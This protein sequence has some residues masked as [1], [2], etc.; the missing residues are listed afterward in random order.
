M[1][2]LHYFIQINIPYDNKIIFAN[3]RASFT[4]QS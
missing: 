2:V 1:Y 3:Y 4:I